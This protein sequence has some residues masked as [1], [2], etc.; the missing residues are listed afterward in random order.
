MSANASSALM[1]ATPSAGNA[2]IQRALGLGD[3]VDRTHAFE[4]RG[5]ML[6]T[7]PICG[8]AM[9]SEIGDVARL[10]GAHFE[11]GEAASSGHRQQGQRQADLVVEVARV[12]V[13]AARAGKGSPASRRLDR[14]LAIR[15][16]DADH[17][18]IARWRAHRAAMFAEC[19]QAVGDD[20]LRQVVSTARS[21]SAGDAPRL[22][23][24]SDEIVGVMALAAQGHEQ[25]AV[26]QLARVGRDRR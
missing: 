9:R 23:R 3:A 14:G 19:A 11:H 16:G 26:G 22:R 6:L 2:G 21:T 1:T 13:G 4:M 18:D 12:D 25:R 17:A 20:D 7:R 5:A 8:C 15:S 24:R 10:A